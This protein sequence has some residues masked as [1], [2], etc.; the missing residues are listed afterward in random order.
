MADRIKGITVE[1]GGDTTGLKKALEGVNK[2]IRDTQ[3]QLKDVNKLLKLDP[4]NTELLSQKQKLLKDAV[5]DTT[6]KLDALQEAQRQAKEQLEKG[7]L[8][9]DKYNALARE[10]IETEQNLKSLKEAQHQTSEQLESAK[11]GQDRF[12]ALGEEVVQAEHNLKSLKEESK[13]FGSVFSEQMDL[14]G[15]KVK[16]VGEKIST[17]GDNMTKYV[18]AP[19]AAAGAASMAA[20]SEVDDAMD[21][22]IKKTGAYGDDLAGLQNVV[23]DLATTIPT[24]FEQAGIAVGEVNTRFGLTG[25]ALYDLSAQFIKFAELNSTDV[26]SSIDMTQK[27]L[28]AFNLTAEDAGTVLDYLNAAGQKTGADLSTLESTLITNAAAF[29]QMGFSAYDAISFLGQVEMSGTDTSAVM[30]GLKKALQN[31]TKEGKPM[32]EALA[33]IQKS[34]LNASSETKGLQAAAEL[35]GAKAG[36]AIYKACKDGSLDFTKLGATAEENIGSVANTFDATQD[37]IDQFTL[38]MNEL[39]QLGY[40]IGEALG[41][42]IQMI[43]DTVIPVIRQLADAWKSLSPET[44]QLIINIALIMAAIGP[45]IS[46]IGSVITGI[47]SLISSIS[48]ISGAMST[49]ALGPIGLVIAAVVALIAIIVLL[50]KN[51]DTVKEIAINVWNSIVEKVKEAW[52]KIKEIFTPLVEFFQ[53][54]WNGLVN[55]FNGAPEWFR[56]VF[57]SALQSVEAIWSAITGF[58][59]GLW[60]GIKA[61]YSTVTEWFSS[62]FSSALNAVKTVWSA[63]T[64]FFT[65][66]WNGIKNI[67]STVSSWFSNM[68]TNAWNGI[69]S[70]FSNVCSFFSGVWNTIKSGFQNLNPFSWGSDMING[71]ANGIRSAVGSV[72]SA[73]SSIAG[74]IKSWL[75][76]SRPD[77]GPLRQYEKWMPDMIQGMTRSLRNSR[78]ILADAL[79][80]MS[81]DMSLSLNPSVAG[82]SGG[83]TV[84]NMITVNAPINGT[85]PSDIRDFARRVADEI[86]SEMNRKSI[87]WK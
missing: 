80:E 65:N 26:N 15:K 4:S 62:V 36:P 71:L 67:F 2:S 6:K 83:T 82:A 85:A 21:T 54:L 3:S 53:G 55:I 56:S 51:W 33:D 24:T 7:T 68:F 42:L 52:E 14:A 5:S 66:I 38:A 72:T 49:L 32:N 58:F 86:Q 39:K 74:T 17:V 28:K 41:P 30:T 57:D 76:F 69:K 12:S 29:D 40:E 1:I 34:M 13:K 75:H 19:I 61:V 50:V 46:V 10:V 77:T 84:S 35:F 63:V 16:E 11:L 22:V 23:M 27:V 60:D 9:Q 48:I 78:H 37:P 79:E 8:G 73:V 45:V 44:Q 64:G 81:T 87:A 70:A 18:T 20:W 59:T 25:D 43:A 31:A 47:G